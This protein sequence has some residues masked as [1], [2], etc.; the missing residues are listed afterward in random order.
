MTARISLEELEDRVLITEMMH[1]YCDFVDT[2]QIDRLLGLF[3][4]DALLDMGNEALFQGRSELRSLLVDRLGL[5]TSTNHHVSN[6]RFVEY[7]GRSATTV[8]YIYA[9]HQKPEA[10]EGM[11]LWGRYLDELTKESADW[12]IR[13][14]RLRVAG[15]SYAGAEA[16][17]ERF[18][19]FARDPL[20][21]R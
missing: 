13:V 16:I 15:V 17:P 6:V 9:F 7:D 2:C 4:D 3:T 8:S 14:R 20:P 5:W 11:H 18:D 1:A 21:E 12:R 19:R 10:N